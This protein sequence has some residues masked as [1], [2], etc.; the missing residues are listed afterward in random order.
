MG[1]NGHYQN[2]ID[3]TAVTVLRFYSFLIVQYIAYD[4]STTHC[5]GG[6]L[7]KLLNGV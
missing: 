7:I 2:L 1:V 4:I 3:T 5:L 6:T